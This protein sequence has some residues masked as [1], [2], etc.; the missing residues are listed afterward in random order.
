MSHRTRIASSFVLAVVARESTT[1]HLLTVIV[2]GGNGATATHSTVAAQLIDGQGAVDVAKHLPF[3]A[4]LVVLGGDEL[5]RSVVDD[6]DDLGRLLADGVLVEVVLV[7]GSQSTDVDVIV[8]DADTVDANW[9]DFAID[10]NGECP[11][12][13]LYLVLF[14]VEAVTA[15]SVL[16]DLEDFF[17]LFFLLES[18][19]F[20]SLERYFFR[21][22]FWL[23]FVAIFWLTKG[24]PSL[25]VGNCLLPKLLVRFSACLFTFSKPTSTYNNNA[26]DQMSDAEYVQYQYYQ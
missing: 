20:T 25:E 4:L 8:D 17:F 23:I 14:D 12:S 15:V 22:S 5:G 6:A 7:D 13:K 24:R 16:D 2:D 26:A 9:L 19:E 3:L 1:R 10:W 18:D 11:N 21:Y